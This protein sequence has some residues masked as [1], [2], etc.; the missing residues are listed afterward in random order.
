MAKRQRERHIHVSPSGI[1]ASI[2]IH[3]HLHQQR[4]KRDTPLVQ[5]RQWLLT[6]EMAYR[7]RHT[8]RTGKFADDALA[9]LESVKSMP[10]YAQREQHIKEWIEVFSDQRRDTIASDQIATQ[11]HRWRTEPR[12]IVKRGGKAVTLILSAAAVNKRRTA[13]MHLYR[14]LDGRAARNPVKDTPKFREPA[15]APRGIPYP[16]VRAILAKMP[17]SKSKARLM[18]MAYTGIPPA[19]IAELTEADV[20]F[21]ARTVAVAGRRKGRG[22]LGRIVPLT[23][24][25]VRALEAMRREDAW[26]PFSRTVMARAF[27]RACKA[28]KAGEGLRAYDL[29]HAFGTEVYAKSGDIR[30][31]QILMG[32]STPQLTHRYTLAAVDPRVQAAIASMA[33]A[34]KVASEVAKPRKIKVERRK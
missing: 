25:G 7:G 10:T 21:T 34:A 31:T 22:T 28:A 8:R 19:Q 27:T 3:G 24:D 23:A 9:Y 12:T 32:H 11:L 20:D 13:L 26:G 16:T 14:T 15:P 33:P 5:V 29:R 4:F 2:R 18:V 30:A 6:T 17:E 1:R